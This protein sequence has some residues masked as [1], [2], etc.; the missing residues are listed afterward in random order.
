MNIITGVMLS[1]VAIIAGMAAA[2]FGKVHTLEFALDYDFLTQ[3]ISD[4]TLGSGLHFL[5]GP[6]HRLIRYP[7]TL[8]N[9]QFSSDD[10]P[11]DEL[12]AR[13]WLALSCAG[14]VLPAAKFARLATVLALL[15]LELANRARLARCGSC[16]VLE[17]TRLA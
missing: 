9:M 16:A 13:T 7:G 1:I 5:G 14:A 10:S 4:Q 2:S 6:W 3:T 11:H 15:V 8:Q 17:L 12:H